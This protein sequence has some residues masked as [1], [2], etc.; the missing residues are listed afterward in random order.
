MNS[1][2][3]KCVMS[4]VVPKAKIFHKVWPFL[5]QNFR[6]FSPH[7]TKNHWFF[8][9]TS[10]FCAK[11]PLFF[12]I[13]WPCCT[14]SLWVS[15]RNFPLLIQHFSEPWFFC[16]IL[17]FLV[18]IS[19]IFPTLL[20]T[21]HQKS[22]GVHRIFSLLMSYVYPLLGPTAS[23]ILVDDDDD[24]FTGFPSSNANFPHAHTNIPPWC[25]QNL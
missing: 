4:W 24:V 23:R 10:L 7:C 20:A 3:F 19:N 22:F 15:H 18:Q 2:E 8:T 16:R 6:R 1:P 5:V 25:Q 9:G 17:P 11:F 21:L 13:F 14:K 12:H